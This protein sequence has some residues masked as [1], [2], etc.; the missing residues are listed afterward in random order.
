MDIQQFRFLE[1]QKYR[2]MFFLLQSEG[3]LYMSLVLPH[4]VM[5]AVLTQLH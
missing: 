2:K 1:I 4:C 5:L 3:D